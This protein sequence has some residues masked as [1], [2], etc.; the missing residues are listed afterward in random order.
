MDVTRRR[1]T[2]NDNDGI[3]RNSD[4]PADGD[5]PPRF[6]HQQILRVLS[7]IL[8]CIFLAAIDQTVVIPAVPAIAADLNGFQH[9]AWI[10]SAYLLTSTAATP[11]YGKLSDIYGRRNLAAG[12]AGGVRRRLGA[13]RH[14]R[15]P[16][17]AGHRPGAAG[18]RRSR[19]DGH[20][21][22]GDRRRGQP[23]GARALP[24][25]HGL[26]LGHRL[27]RRADHRRLGHRHAVVALDLLG[28]PADRADRHG[29]VRSRLA[30]AAGA[31]R[32]GAH[33]LGRRR[34]AHRRGQRLAA[35]A[36]LGR[37]GDAVDRAADPWPSAPPDWC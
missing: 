21:T 6:T 13:V 26:H 36:E 15:H 16:R 19:P 29:A 12:R 22:G 34:P 4:M 24:G 8:L 2:G 11:I 20:G 35:G 5:A 32:T 9:L 1:V 27:D 31:R 7:G 28:Q 17:P 14:G 25:L 37:G 30:A 3:R 18:H 23:A 10:V 33:R